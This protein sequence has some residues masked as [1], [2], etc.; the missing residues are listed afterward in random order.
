MATLYVASLERRHESFIIRSDNQGSIGQYNKGRSRNTESNQCVRRATVV[1]M[2][3][4][5]DI[6]PFYVPSA[7]NRADRSS[8]GLDLF[9]STRLH[10]SFSLPAA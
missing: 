9:D 6:L 1:M 3:G 2:N 8:R 5:F 7:L 4:A 10:N